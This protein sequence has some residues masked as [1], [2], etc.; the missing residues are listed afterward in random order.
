MN[1]PILTITGVT[2]Y[3]LLLITITSV[4]LDSVVLVFT[5]VEFFQMIHYGMAKDVPLLAR[6][7]NSTDLHGFALLFLKL[8]LKTWK[9][10]S[11][12][13]KVILMKTL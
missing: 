9:Y 13:T 10:D 12:E 7:V 4:N 3:H 1:V 6:A 2:P 5:M 8:Q 11:V